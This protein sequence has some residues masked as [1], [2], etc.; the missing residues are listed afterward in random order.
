MKG[1]WLPVRLLSIFVA[2]TLV[3]FSGMTVAA[4]GETY[5]Q[6][7]DASV[8]VSADAAAGVVFANDLPSNTSLFLPFMLTRPFVPTGVLTG[9]DVVTSPDGVKLGAV[10]GAL[11]EDLAVS[12]AKTVAPSHPMPDRTTPLGDYFL[13]AAAREVVQPLDKS[14]ILALP[15]PVGAE[16]DHLAI[17]LYTS[18]SGLLDQDYTDGYYWQFLPGVYDP[19]QNLLM[20]PFPYLAQHGETVVLIEHPDMPSP[21]RGEASDDVAARSFDQFSGNFGVA[22]TT[23]IVCSDELRQEVAN[24]LQQN[25]AE[26]LNVHGYSLP[27]LAGSGSDLSIDP[28]ELNTPSDL[29]YGFIFSN[30]QAGCTDLGGATAYAGKYNARTGSL[31]IC[32]APGSDHLSDFEK[33]TVRHEYFH[34]L[35]FG[36]DSVLDDWQAGVSENW[37]VEGLADAVVKSS[38]DWKRSGSNAV[39]PVDKPL[40]DDSDLLEYQAEDLWVFIGRNRIP[41]LMQRLK[42]VLVMGATFDDVFTNIDFATD[43]WLW[44]RNQALEKSDD[45]DGA[46]GDECKLEEQAVSDLRVWDINQNIT[47]DFIG[48]T[49]ILSSTV[50]ELKF[51]EGDW[52]GKEANIYAVTLPEGDLPP[53]YFQYKVYRTPW[54]NCSGTP[55]NIPQKYEVTPGERYFVL[56]VNWYQD[57]AVTWKILFE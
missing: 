51:D 2:I 39:R 24:E 26:F 17:A 16:T 38:A 19:N 20:T 3:V 43:F 5:V 8:V 7:S 41:A 4:I 53:P 22:C 28:P 14:F 21:V 47:D 35:E 50:V 18:T 1:T 25:Y 49:P 40:R 34:A 55:A 30:Q 46:L 36:Y 12:M 56:I 23:S 33:D 52:A 37:I 44:V 54:P 10:A 9:G 48:S 45:M 29:Y 42:Q 27:R 13:I 15:V 32:L 57:E 31:F 6:G 11:D